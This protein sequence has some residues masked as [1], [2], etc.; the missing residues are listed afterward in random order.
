MGNL[1]NFYDTNNLLSCIGKGFMLARGGN[2]TGRTNFNLVC[3]NLESYTS[4][5]YFNLK[6]FKYKLVRI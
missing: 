4:V 3:S 5:G 6:N 2:L 1:T